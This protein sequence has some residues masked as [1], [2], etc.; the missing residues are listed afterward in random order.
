VEWHR[1]GRGRT[2]AFTLPTENL[3]RALESAACTLSDEFDLLACGREGTGK[4]SRSIFNV[5][6]CSALSFGSP[7]QYFIRSRALSPGLP[8]A[9]ALTGLGWPSV[10]AVN[11][12]VIVDH[13]SPLKSNPS[14]S[15]IGVVHRV[16][17][18]VT[19]EPLVHSGYDRIF[20]T[21]KRRIALEVGTG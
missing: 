18:N 17:H 6:P 1:D 5:L 15:R 4:G 16:R 13:P 20:R 8:D 14:G 7:W 19:N 21:L 10:F 11:G 12:L 9:T 2:W 3:I